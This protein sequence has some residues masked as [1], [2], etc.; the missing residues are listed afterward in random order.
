MT[1]AKPLRNQLDVRVVSV[2]GHPVRDDSGQ[3]RL[4]PPSIATVRAARATVGS[5]PREIG[6]TQMPATLSGCRRTGVSI[7]SSG[8]PMSMP[9]RLPTNNGETD[10]RNGR[11]PA[12][13]DEHCAERATRHQR[14]RPRERLPVGGNRLQPPQEIAWHRLIVRPKKSFTCVL[15]MSTA[16]PFV[17]PIT[18]G[19]G[20]T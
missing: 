13:S 11:Q 1:F 7:V 15:A 14:G 5:G 20:C 6:A 17:K 10:P 16:I 2:P 4:D 12:P 18:T 9:Q 8:S 19:R 3:K